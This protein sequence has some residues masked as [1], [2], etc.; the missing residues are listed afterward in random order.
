MTALLTTL[1]LGASSES[2][3]RLWGFHVTN[4]FNGLPD[5]MPEALFFGL[6]QLVAQLG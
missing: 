2:F 6:V 3:D 1:L 5:V 4:S